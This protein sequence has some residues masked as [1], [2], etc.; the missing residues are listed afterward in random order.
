MFEQIFSNLSKIILIIAGIACVILVLKYFQNIKKFLIEVKVE[1]TK[2]S[3]S[4]RKELV[5]ATWLVILTTGFL[6]IFIGVI[7]FALSKILS[8]LI[9]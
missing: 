9:K 4:T 7:D 3:W 5:S 8:L 6:G 2:V 1:L